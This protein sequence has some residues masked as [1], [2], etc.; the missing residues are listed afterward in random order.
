MN[1]AT[2]TNV[3]NI[4]Y[5]LANILLHHVFYL[6]RLRAGSFMHW[7]LRCKNQTPNKASKKKDAPDIRSRRI[8]NKHK[9]SLCIWN[10]RDILHHVWISLFL[11]FSSECC[12]PSCM[13]NVHEE[14][15]LKNDACAS[16]K[17]TWKMR[18]TEIATQL[19]SWNMSYGFY[20]HKIGTADVFPWQTPNINYKLS[21]PRC[22]LLKW[23]R[24]WVSSA[25]VLVQGQFAMNKATSSKLNCERE[26][27][28]S[29]K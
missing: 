13:K 18:T 19:F 15:W 11:S 8:W 21:Y 28:I 23:A 2:G 5:I 24:K 17:A 16:L 29:P 20:K 25:I 27:M 9:K 14:R 7:F 10:V 4:V 12:S 26:S 1:A 22:R 6:C 3:R